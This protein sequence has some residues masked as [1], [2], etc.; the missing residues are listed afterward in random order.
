MC[1]NGWSIYQF[2]RREVE[3]DTPVCGGVGRERVGRRRREMLERNKL[4][5][6]G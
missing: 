5:G 1:M 3:W 4:N 6:G 2:R